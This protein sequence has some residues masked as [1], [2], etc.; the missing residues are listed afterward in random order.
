MGCEVCGGTGYVGRCPC[1]DS[2][3][4]YSGPNY[5]DDP[6]GSPDE[7]PDCFQGQRYCPQCETEANR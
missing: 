6:D 5:T 7:C 4:V 1:L 2:G 3:P